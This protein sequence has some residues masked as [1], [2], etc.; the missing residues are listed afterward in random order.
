MY[1]LNNFSYLNF[2]NL[3]FNNILLLFKKILYNNKN[4]E[5]KSNTFN[6]KYYPSLIKFSSSK[7][8]KNNNSYYNYNQL[9]SIISIYIPINLIFK[10]TNKKIKF[11]FNIL[12]IPKIYQNNY[13]TIK[14]IKRVILSSFN[15]SFK[16]Y[17]NIRK[18]KILIS[19]NNTYSIKI[20]SNNFIN[21]N[22][23]LIKG[24][25]YKFNII[26]Y[27]SIYNKHYNNLKKINNNYI[28]IFNIELFKFFVN[29]I[30]YITF[31]YNN[32]NY[33]SLYY[34]YINNISDY[35]LKPIKNLKY[36]PLLFLKNSQILKYNNTFSLS[37][38]LI[39][40]GIFTHPLIQIVDQTNCLSELTH[41]YKINLSNETIYNKLTTQ[42]NIRLIKN[43]YITKLSL[44]ST[45]EGK[46][47]GLVSSIIHL[48][49]FNNKKIKTIL[50][51][52][53]KIFN[54][55]KLDAL[56]TIFFK[57]NFINKEINFKKYYNINK[58][59]NIIEFNEFKLNL[60]KNKNY[61]NLQN[62]LSFSESI[63][64]FILYNDPCRGIMGSKMHNQALPLINSDIPHIFSKNNK[65]NKI[66]QNNCLI[67]N[68]NGI[69]IYSDNY[70]IIIQDTKNRI[71]TYNTQSI[72]INNYIS[73]FKNSILVWPGDNVYYGSILSTNKNYINLELSLGKN[74]L[75][76]Y[77]NYYGYDHEDAI[78]LKKNLIYNDY[79]LSIKFN[80]Y[81]SYIDSNNNSYEFINI[82]FLNKN[83]LLTE[84]N[85]IIQKLKLNFNN[86]IHIKN[87]SFINFNP[88]LS[89]YTKINAGCSC[90]ISK[91]QLNNLNRINNNINNLIKI[92]I[93][94]INFD[95]I[96]IGDKLCGRHGN[97]GIIS[98]MLDIVNIPYTN[99]DLIPDILITSISSVSR[100]NIG[101]V[102]EGSCGYYSFLNK[103]RLNIPYFIDT[104][105][106]MN[107]IFNIFNLSYKNKLLYKYKNN[108][109]LIKN[110]LLGSGY[111]N[112]ITILCSYYLKLSHIIKN[113]IKFRSIG[114]YNEITQQ[115]DENK[116]NEKGQRFGEMEF[117]ALESHCSPFNLKE[118]Y[119]IK[120]SKSMYNNKLLIS[121]IHNSL[122]TEL[123]GL[124]LNKKQNYN[125]YIL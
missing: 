118:L 81:E 19:N 66:T 94:T 88:I 58:Y 78:I 22:L 92:N 108:K 36:R 79:M 30:T 82:N 123:I 40:E 41:I 5:F 53:N 73:S 3:L 44:L 62:I 93:I 105:N 69:I 18:N 120:S 38:C 1:I 11:I 110:P 68:S 83:T 70:K 60:K 14:G 16:Y 47:A 26:N 124:N 34:K 101:Q 104:Y 8:Y 32:I 114:K 106:F 115:P 50:N 39:K 74:I 125:E 100:I 37:E 76:G 96:S 12:S 6:I 91:I 13:T 48:N 2:K 43:D 10:T 117:W 35:I 77:C 116:K 90:R 107:N 95:K 45:S 67:S 72:K 46:S 15:S 121:D 112:N 17:S 24:I 65:I 102:L 57:N 71:I 89:D 85:T 99:Y 87:L 64:P 21:I 4:F 113:K 42:K 75:I 28:N 86:I 84:F 98:C 97:K 61:N 56:S 20:N 7:I 51:S 27:Y 52:E 29:I 25:K 122:N 23:N 54:N 55:I 103:I 33:D 49:Y 63:I 80:I 31:N 119:Y 109:I 111:Y 9:T 59:N